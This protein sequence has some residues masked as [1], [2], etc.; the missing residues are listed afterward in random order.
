M[1]YQ[2]VAG[3]AERLCD[4]VVDRPEGVVAGGLDKKHG[5]AATSCCIVHIRCG[6]ALLI[7]V[8]PAA[9]TADTM[10]GPHAGHKDM[11]H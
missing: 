9:C 4:E 10:P 7:A 6:L 11:N 8:M 3:G 5:L 2:Q 1:T